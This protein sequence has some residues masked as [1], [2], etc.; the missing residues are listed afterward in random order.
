[1]TGDAMGRF[2]YAQELE[3]GV[4]VPIGIARLSVMGGWTD[5]SGWETVDIEVNNLAM[6][7]DNDAMESLLST[8]DVNEADIMKAGTSIT[9]DLGNSSA[10]HGGI[11]LSIPIGS[12]YEV[13]PAAYYAGTTIPDE[14]FH[15]GIVD[16][17]AYDLRLSASHT[18][19]D[20]LTVG[21]SF[22][23][24]V[25][26]DRTV[27]NSSLSF[28]NK[29]NSGRTLNSANGRYTM[30]AHRAGLTLIARR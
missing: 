2:T 23:H 21:L 24:F 22:D 3:L 7:S 25:V 13:R 9:N 4:V 26:P 30:R 8:T 15:A 17:P 27:R 14:T 12:R 16:F 20:W 29:A 19:V 5:W 1:M 10:F 6:S 18:P 11:G 28:D